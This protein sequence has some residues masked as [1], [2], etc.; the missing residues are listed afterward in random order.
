MK[1]KEIRKFK[2]TRLQ[3]PM[4]QGNSRLNSKKSRNVMNKVLSF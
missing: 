4:L 3:C 2:N 1:Y